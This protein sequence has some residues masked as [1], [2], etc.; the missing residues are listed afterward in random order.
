M[1]FFKGINSFSEYL[2]YHSE[3]RSGLQ[4]QGWEKKTLGNCIF[5]EKQTRKQGIC[6]IEK[7]TR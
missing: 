7:L 5:C 4:E 1:C 3:K 6:L 2:H